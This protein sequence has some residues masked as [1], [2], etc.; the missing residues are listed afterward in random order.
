LQVLRFLVLT[1]GLVVAAAPA[2]AE[3]CTEATL[4][5]TWLSVRSGNLWTFHADGTLSCDGACRFTEV[6]GDPVSWAYE[7]NANIWSKPIDYVKLV[8]TKSVFEGVFGSF[9]CVIADAGAT[10]RLESEDDPPMVFSRR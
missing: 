1:A 2:W 5:G 3:R 7:P 9:R 4:P 6:T 8:F 10:L